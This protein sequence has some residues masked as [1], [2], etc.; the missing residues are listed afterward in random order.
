[1]GVTNKVDIVIL[2]GVNDNNASK[3]EVEDGWFTL[4]VELKWSN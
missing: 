2:T 4:E 1:L 3:S